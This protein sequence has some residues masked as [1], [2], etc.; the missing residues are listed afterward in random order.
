MEGVLGHSWAWLLDHFQAR[1]RPPPL[2]TSS[3]FLEDP[4]KA[5]AG[6]RELAGFPTNSH[7]VSAQIKIYLRDMWL[8]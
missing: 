1:L 7:Q 3:Q 4:L 6:R 2:K 5:W 8:P